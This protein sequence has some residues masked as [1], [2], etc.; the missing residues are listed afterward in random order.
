[1]TKQ[2][3]DAD[4]RCADCGYR[5]EQKACIASP[6]EGRSPKFCPIENLPG[7]ISE[8]LAAYQSPD[9]LAFAR[10]ASIQEGQGYADRDKEPFVKKPCKPRIEEIWEFAHTMGYGKLGLAFCAGLMAEARMVAKILIAHGLEVASVMCKVGC[11]PKETLGLEEGEKVRIGHHESMCN[12]IAQAHLLNLAGT[13]LNVVLGLCVG[14]DSL[15]FQHSKAPCTVLAVKDRVTGHN[16]LAAV[17]TSG[18]YYERL[19]TESD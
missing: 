5:K 12:P 13:D 10:Q 18:S 4:V 2:D 6:G 19:N 3:P 8:A 7:V 14:H 15:F 1:M 17:Y 16:P 9:T 11:E